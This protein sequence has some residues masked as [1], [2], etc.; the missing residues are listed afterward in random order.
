MWPSSH[1]K[2]KLPINLLSQARQW[3]P[4]RMSQVLRPRLIL[5]SPAIQILATVGASSIV[6]G[7]FNRP[8]MESGGC[9]AVWADT[10]GFGRG[11][12][13][14]LG[15]TGQFEGFEAAVVGERVELI[16]FVAARHQVNPAGTTPL[17]RFSVFLDCVRYMP[18]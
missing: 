5:R 6:D 2:S 18:L 12:G 16:Y 4:T 10:V 14:E 17:P 13:F 1:G 9:H 8:G 7:P 3:T 15:P 11:G